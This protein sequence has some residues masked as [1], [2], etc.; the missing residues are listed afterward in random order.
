L[1]KFIYEKI[2]IC[3]PTNYRLPSRHASRVKPHDFLTS[4]ILPAGRQALIDIPL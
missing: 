3:Q 4:K 1:K 2:A